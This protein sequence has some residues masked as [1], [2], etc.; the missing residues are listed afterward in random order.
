M[1]D[2]PTLLRWFDDGRLVR[3]SSAVPNTVA[4]VRA[5]ASLNDA[6][7]GPLDDQAQRIATAIGEADHHVFIL[8]DGLGMNLLESQPAGAFLRPHVAMEL[9]A[10]FPSTTAA[11]IT[12]IA[13]GLWPAEHAVPAWWTYLPDHGVT[14]TILPFIERFSQRPLQELGVRPDDAL[15]AQVTLPRFT[16]DV[17]AYMPRTIA[18]STYTRYFRGGTACRAYDGLGRAV[19]AIA[20]RIRSATRRTYSYLYIP[21]IDAAE[22]L[23]GVASHQAREAL[24]AV[25]RA[26]ARL[27]ELVATRAR[28]VLS[29][30]HGLL[31]VPRERVHIARRD[32]DLMR[33]LAAP[34]YGEPRVPMFTVRDGCAEAFAACFRRQYGETFAL[35]T[36]DEAD[37][38]RLFGPEPL[39]PETRRRIGGFLA[40]CANPD[41]LVYE[42]PDEIM[43]GYHAGLTAEEMRIPLVIR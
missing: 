29:A 37:E 42:P 15:P 2:L 35:L 21:S 3:P 40:L 39:A 25:D 23:F 30:D 32:D 4:L 14:A 20:D 16:S 28:I 9:Q 22:H 7:D 24:E 31:D 6:R 38:L 10:V 12:S 26:V 13:T 41:V 34:P 17:C 19:E 27:A 43:R 33:H 18:G 36:V 5:L 1:S 11:A 8:A